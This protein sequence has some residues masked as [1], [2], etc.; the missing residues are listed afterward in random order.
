MSP[1]DWA[2]DIILIGYCIP[3]INMVVR[4]LKISVG[5]ARAAGDYSKEVRVLLICCTEKR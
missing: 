4:A 3:E 1:K 5:S 2:D